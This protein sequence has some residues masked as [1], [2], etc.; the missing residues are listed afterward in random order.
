MTLAQIFSF[1][2]IAA[3]M[4]LFVWGR[5]RYDLVA[6]LALLAAIA[7]G[8]VP[9]DK[10]FSG[11]SDDIVIIVA[12]ALLVSAA[13]G[14]SGV[15]EDALVRIGP[16]LT[17]R[18]IQVAVLVGT[19]TALSAFVKNIGALAMLMPVAFQLARKTNGSPSIYLMP[20]AF[21]SLLG[22]IVTLVGTSPNI[23]VAR[24]RAELVGE[25]FGMFDFTP[26]GIGLAIA[27]V[28]VPQLRLAA[29]AARPQGR[30]RDRCRIHARRL[31]HRS[32]R[33]GER[34]R[35]SAR[36]SASSKP[37]RRASRCSCWCAAARAGST[38]ADDTGIK[39][40]DI[41]LIEGEPAALDR[42]VDKAGLKLAREETEQ[43]TDTP[44]DEIG[45]MEAVVGEDSPLVGRTAAQEKLDERYG[46]H[47]LA[48][49]RRG[50]RITQ[51]MRA[52]RL[53]KGDVI[54]L[55]GHL[56]SLPETLGELR[57]LPLAARD[58]R[59]GRRGPQHAA[60]LDPGARDGV[61]RRERD[62]GVDRVLFR[63]GRDAADPRAHPA[64]SL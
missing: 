47:L 59:L 12:C 13:V 41:L 4:A 21:G 23:I 36:P 39:A 22:G 18:T 6:L 30:G 24:L 16:Y 43:A 28:G 20:M 19:V 64:R 14:R 26:V 2:I 29:A 3:T 17:T 38:P 58:L 54:V 35:P 32:E 60:A 49:S 7:T 62:P 11:F 63:R 45:V 15:V 33:S 46:V 25:P 48:V 44:T 55:R 31:H 56:P 9:A 27:G 1:G 40:G 61:R 5:L 52:V 42:L 37:C 10:A 34:S 51:R 53:E 8:I 50:K 57:C